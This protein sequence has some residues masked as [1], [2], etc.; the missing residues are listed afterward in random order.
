M[1]AAGNAPLVADAVRVAYGDEI[2]VREATFTV[3][4]SEIVA[5]MGPSGSGKSS[6]LRACAALIPICEGRLVVCG[7]EPSLLGE[8]A[9]SRLR[10]RH[11]GLVFQF[12]DL[13]PELSL[14]DNVALPLELLG[15]GRRDSLARARG[16]LARVGLKGTA[17]DRAAA[18]VSGGQA[19]RAAVARALVTEPGLLL[20]DEPTGSLDSANGRVIMDLIE[21]TRARGTAVLIVTHD[22]SVAGRADR[23]LTMKDGV[24]TA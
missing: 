16:W 1:E 17:I 9:R 8:R 7:H 20:A 18:K 10:L 5:I 11:V 4:A 19:Q 12:P 24:L 13:L 15:E 21:E 23:I 6:T 2:A 3:Q 22:R 14:L